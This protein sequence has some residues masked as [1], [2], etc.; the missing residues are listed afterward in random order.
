MRSV[1]TLAGSVQQ[2]L[3]P[4]PVTAAGDAGASSAGAFVSA[5][6]AAA[7]ECCRSSAWSGVF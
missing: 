2:L 3:P 1:N 6:A 7:T 5:A 4:L